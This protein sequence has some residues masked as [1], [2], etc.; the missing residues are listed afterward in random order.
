MFTWK[1]AIHTAFSSVDQAG[2]SR[3]LPLQDKYCKAPQNI[4]LDLES[5]GTF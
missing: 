2:Y 3:T 5:E 1:E 4:A